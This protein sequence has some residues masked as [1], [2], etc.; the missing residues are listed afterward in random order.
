M[1]DEI[2]AVDSLTSSDIDFRKMAIE[3]SVPV[4]VIDNNSISIAR[5]VYPAC[6]DNGAGICGQDSRSGAIGDVE[7]FVVPNEALGDSS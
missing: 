3:S 1:A 7:T 4:S 6:C 2:A 5:A